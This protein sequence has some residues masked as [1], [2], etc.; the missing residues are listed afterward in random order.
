[1]SRVSVL[2]GSSV[3][4]PARIQDKILPEPNTGCWL[5]IAALNSKGYG[6]CWHKGSARQAHV[7]VY[8][9]LVGPATPEL[10]HRCR[11]RCCVN[12]D[13]M[14]R[15]TRGENLRRSTCWHHLLQKRVRE[16]S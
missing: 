2:G 10:D 1:M 6:S 15:V 5:W 11:N 13:H 3:T 16:P 7:V 12:P 8:E 4:L 14:D 9:M